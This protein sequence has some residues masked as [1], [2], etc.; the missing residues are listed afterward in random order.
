MGRADLPIVVATAAFSLG[1][2]FNRCKTVVHT[3][4]PSTFSEYVQQIGRAGRSGEVCNAVLLF[5]PEDVDTY[6]H[7]WVKS[8]EVSLLDSAAYH[9]NVNE[10]KYTSM[11]VCHACT[12]V[13]RGTYHVKS[14]SSPHVTR[15]A[16]M[17]TTRF[18][19]HI[20]S[21]MPSHVKRNLVGH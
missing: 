19:S 16:S 8:E 9:R 17:H 4:V 6:F 18:T 1:V 20:Y 3:C 5:R 2:N 7:C 21:Y 14:E 12:Y 10:R 13:T 11:H 15:H